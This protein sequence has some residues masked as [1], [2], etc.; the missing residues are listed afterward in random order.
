MTSPRFLDRP[1]GRIAYDLT[2]DGPLVVCIPGVGDTRAEYRFLAPRL[3][4]AG[5]QVATL[6]LRGHGASDASFRD[7]T[8]PAVGSDVVALLE[9]LG[10]G[11]DHGHG[12]AHLIGCSLGASAAV[13]AAAEAPERVASLTL[14][15]PFVRDVPM[16]RMKSL[17]QRAGLRLLLSRPWGPRA[18][19]AWYAKLYPGSPPADLAEHRAAL[20]ANLAEPGRLEACRILATSSC[21]QIEPR[22][23]EVGVP[24][25]VLMGTADPDFPDPAAEAA[26][27]A[28]RTG[29]TAV[30]VE[31]AG[32]YPHVEA[33]ER[34]AAEILRFLA[35]PA[36]TV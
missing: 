22:L 9:A 2:G 4:A 36:A 15:G 24:T 28:E 32:H 30:L 8:R 26:W 6:D 16:P 21:A 23:S 33:A 10:A 34:T 14:I 17:A 20:A 18:W 3:V 1:G 29:G 27:V 19:S 31:G 7:L 13:W 5:F 12:P 25:T 11:G 35:S